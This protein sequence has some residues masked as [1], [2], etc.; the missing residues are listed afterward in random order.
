MSARLSRLLLNLRAALSGAIE[1]SAAVRSALEQLEAAGLSVYLVVDDPESDRD[2][3]AARLLPE[4]SRKG[5]RSPDFR[6]D[7]SDLSLL[8]DLGIDPTRTIRRGRR[9]KR[10]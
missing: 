9:A 5:E 8:R 4:P 7:Q 10:T 6:I 3:E 1:S 2:P